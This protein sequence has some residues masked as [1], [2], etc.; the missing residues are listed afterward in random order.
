MVVFGCKI[1]KLQF[2]MAKMRSKIAKLDPKWLRWDPKWPS[3]GLKLVSW[4]AKWP[5][6]GLVSRRLQKVQ[7]RGGRYQSRQVEILSLLTPRRKEHFPA[8][9]S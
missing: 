3:W 7:F 6:W 4:G 2:K 9:G 8:A 5:C 1:A